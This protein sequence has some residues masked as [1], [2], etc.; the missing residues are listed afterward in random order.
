MNTKI[1]VQ[2]LESIFIV[3]V[4]DNIFKTNDDKMLFKF[5]K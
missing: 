4:F 2:E 5:E 3:C 1:C